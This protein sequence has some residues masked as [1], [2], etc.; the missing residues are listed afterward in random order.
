MNEFPRPARP[1]VL[2]EDALKAAGDIIGRS[3]ATK[4]EIGYVNDEAVRVDEAGWFAWA[5]YSGTRIIE[6]DHRDPVAAAEALARRILT[7]AICQ[8]CQGLISMQD[9]GAI[10]YPGGIMRDGSIMTEERARS[11]RQ[12]RWTR[13]GARWEPGCTTARRLA[14]SRKRVEPR[15]AKKAERKKGRR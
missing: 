5:D 13:Q 2:D 6:Q 1:L 4:F 8:H 14:A 12:C 10:V 11:M 7:G 3:G 9:G 15:K